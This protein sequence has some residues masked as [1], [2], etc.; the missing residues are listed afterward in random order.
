MDALVS[1]AAASDLYRWS[2]TFDARVVVY[3]DFK[4]EG[5]SRVIKVTYVHVLRSLKISIFDGN[6]PSL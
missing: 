4:I 5:N 6:C 1:I 3:F 2:E